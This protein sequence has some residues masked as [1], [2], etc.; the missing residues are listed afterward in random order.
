METQCSKLGGKMPKIFH[1]NWFRKDS[2]GK[3]LWPGFGEN[4]RVLDWV[5]KRVDDENCFENSAIGRIPSNGSLNL[6][7]LQNVNLSELF[8]INKEFWTKESNEIQTFFDDQVG[9]DLPIEI[10]EELDDLKKRI[11]TMM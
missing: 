11:E 8:S 1:V 2:K 7:G 6:N 5:L 10:Q 3:F 9:K 4:S